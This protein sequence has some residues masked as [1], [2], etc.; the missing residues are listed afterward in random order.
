MSKKRV[1]EY[2]KIFSSWGSGNSTLEKELCA[3]SNSVQ[4]SNKIADP[5]CGHSGFASVFVSSSSSSWLACLPY[6]YSVNVE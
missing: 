2:I 1:P 4:S 5:F 6:V 3:D